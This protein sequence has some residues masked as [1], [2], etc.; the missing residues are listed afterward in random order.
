MR[1]AIMG[2]FVRSPS[3]PKGVRGKFSTFRIEDI[4]DDKRDQ[5]IQHMKD[6]FFKDEPTTQVLERTTLLTDE[7]INAFLN[8]SLNDNVSLCAID[9]ANND[10]IAGVTILRVSSRCDPHRHE[11]VDSKLKSM[12]RLFHFLHHCHEGIDP[13]TIKSGSKEVVVDHVLEPMGLSV[14]PKY[15]GKGLGQALIQ[16]RH[17]LAAEL[18]IGATMGIYTSIYSQAIILRQGMEMVK[19]ISYTDYKEDGKVIFAELNPPHPS[20]KVIGGLLKKD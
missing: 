19:E 5:A 15:R 1:Q 6:Y 11:K 8:N 4:P 18:G 9:E 13:F 12:Q 17:K 10:E 20:A 2:T 3:V 7:D 14:S 16:A